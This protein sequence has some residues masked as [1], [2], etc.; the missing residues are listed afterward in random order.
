[1]N[2]KIISTLLSFSV[3][4]FVACGNQTKDAPAEA[5]IP[6][7]PDAAIKAILTELSVGDAGVLWDAMPASCQVD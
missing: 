6:E 1:M 4:L 5:A 2:S 3:L 7:A